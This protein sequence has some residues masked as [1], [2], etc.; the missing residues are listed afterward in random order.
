[1]KKRYFTIIGSVVIG[2]FLA[3]AGCTSKYGQ[4]QREIGTEIHP[5]NASNKIDPAFHQ[6]SLDTDKSNHFVIR[7]LISTAGVPAGQK[8]VTEKKDIQQILEYVAAAPKTR[9]AVYDNAPG[10]L[11]TIACPEMQY[12]AALYRGNVL[13]FGGAYYQMDP[14]FTEDLLKF[15][16][17]ID[18]PVTDIQ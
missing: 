3:C 9:P 5:A 18:V 15:F 14:E 6:E 12:A 1:M 7:K 16:D 4:E 17:Q 10:T 13:Y 11:F 8:E 2:L